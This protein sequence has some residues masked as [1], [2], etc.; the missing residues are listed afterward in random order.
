MRTAARA[1]GAF[2]VLFGYDFAGNLGTRFPIANPWRTGIRNGSGRR[3]ELMPTL[4]ESIPWL[5]LLPGAMIVLSAL[6]INIIG[7][8]LHAALDPT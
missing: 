3:S 1:P 8:G 6:S 2:V 4:T 5:W 7:D